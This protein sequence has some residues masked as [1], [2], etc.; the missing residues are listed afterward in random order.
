MRTSKPPRRPL[1][2]KKWHLRGPFCLEGV[3]IG[4][5][6]Q[7]ILPLLKKGSRV[8]PPMSRGSHWQSSGKAAGKQR[9]GGSRSGDFADTLKKALGAGRGTLRLLPSAHK[10]GRTDKGIIAPPKKEPGGPSAPHV[11]AT[12]VPSRSRRP[13]GC[14]RNDER[15]SRATP[16]TQDT[17]QALFTRKLALGARRFRC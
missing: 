12:A 6:D 3:G 14:T 15:T 8:M 10:K 2:R 5:P 4:F 16:D 13:P 7:G 11:R 1:A 17:P 9:A